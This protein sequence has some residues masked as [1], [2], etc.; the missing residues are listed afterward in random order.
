MVDQLNGTLRWSAPPIGLREVA[1]GVGVALGAL[2]QQLYGEPFMRASAGFV[3][4]GAIA[5]P[6]ASL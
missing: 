2:C 4:V 1:V 5:Q 6:H 3:H